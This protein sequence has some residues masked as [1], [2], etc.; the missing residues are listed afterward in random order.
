MVALVVCTV[1]KKTVPTDS[2]FGGHVSGWKRRQFFKTDVM[3]TLNERY[4][5]MQKGDRSSSKCI[6][7]RQENY[8]RLIAG[9]QRIS[10]SSLSVLISH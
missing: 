7:V 6:G 4:V 10:C 2:I 1:K 9:H 3:I 5:E 8:T